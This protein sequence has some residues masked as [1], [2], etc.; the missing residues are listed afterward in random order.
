LL[1]AGADPNSA[2]DSGNT[3]THYAAAF[4]WLSCVDLLKEAGADMSVANAMK[5]APVTAALQKGHTSVFRRMLALGI[6]PNFRDADGSTLLINSFVSATRSVHQEVAFLLEQK[7]DVTLSSSQGQT[8]LHALAS[9]SIPGD[10]IPVYVAR[11]DEAERLEVLKGYPQ[12][13]QKPPQIESGGSFD[14]SDFG[15]GF[16][17]GMR[18]GRRK[19]MS[20]YERMQHMKQMQQEMQERQAEQKKLQ[21]LQRAEVEELLRAQEDAEQVEDVQMEKPAHE[22]GFHQLSTEEREAVFRLGWKE[23]T[24][25][26]GH[27]PTVAWTALTD[28]QRAAAVLLGLGEEKW[29]GCCPS[30]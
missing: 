19:K 14:A 26:A 10:D 6:D 4:G 5:L 13:P 20:R 25:Q 9:I 28:Q 7:A 27:N 16:G 11:F 29:Q 22:R 8:P 17:G 18:G 12:R 1:N 2:D 24:W 23:D 30:A 15:G 21:E 3:V